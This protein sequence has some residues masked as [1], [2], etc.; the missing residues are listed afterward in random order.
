MYDN[1]TKKLCENTTLKKAHDLCS[2]LRCKQT[3]IINL[4]KQTLLTTFC[5]TLLSDSVT[6]TTNFNKLL[7]FNSWFFWGRL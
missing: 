4:E 6:W 2:N 1:T 5:L 7:R 3:W